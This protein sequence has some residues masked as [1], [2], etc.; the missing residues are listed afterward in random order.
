MNRDTY[1]HHNK[2]KT[3]NHIG[4][5]ADS[6]IKFNNILW[7]VMYRLISIVQII[8]LRQTLKQKL[9]QFLS[10]NNE[11]REALYGLLIVK[12]FDS[13]TCI[14]KMTISKCSFSGIDTSIWS[15]QIISFRTA[16]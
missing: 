10:R 3:A 2:T 1:K 4:L 13:K 6:V 11:M 8:Q 12:W 16:Q 9:M 5:K 7:L 15:L 14:Q